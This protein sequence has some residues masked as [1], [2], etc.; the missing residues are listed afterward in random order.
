M[1]EDS[2]HPAI[3][4][5]LEARIVALV[6]GEASDF[7]REQLN[8]LVEQRPELAAFKER[9]QSLHGLL[10]VVAS[11]DSV[12]EDDDW[13]LSNEKRTAVL[14]VISGEAAN[15]PTVR[16]VSEPVKTRNSVKGSLLWKVT[17]IAAILLFPIGFIGSV[18]VSQWLTA[19]ARRTAD[20]RQLAL[21]ESAGAA[22]MDG[23]MSTWGDDISLPDEPIF[24]DAATT[25][26][27]P[28]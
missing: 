11:H 22:A 15:T 17:K 25:L 27:V 28:T 8:R 10:G 1:K 4:P 24:M 12:A 16:F 6:L 9:M 21:N 14:A 26:R 13:K 18:G 5:E 7:E 19:S 2:H 23:A 3:D 20:S